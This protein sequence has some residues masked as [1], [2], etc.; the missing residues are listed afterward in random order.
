MF[1][2]LDLNVKKLV[3]TS[4]VIRILKSYTEASTR[5][6]FFMHGDSSIHSD[7]KKHKK[8]FIVQSAYG[9]CALV[10]FILFR[11]FVNFSLFLHFLEVSGEIIRICEKWFGGV[12]LLFS[13]LSP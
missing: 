2:R 4:K 12:F 10:E 3:T 7:N 6:S 11:E 5:P 8:R 9:C 1:Q 13:A